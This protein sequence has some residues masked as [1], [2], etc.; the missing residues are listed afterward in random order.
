MVDIDQSNLQAILN[1]MVKI[2]INFIILK[3]GGSFCIPD[4]KQ[5]NDC[6]RPNNSIIL[7]YLLFT[8]KQE[9]FYNFFQQRKGKDHNLKKMKMPRKKQNSIVSKKIFHC[10]YTTK[11]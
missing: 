4:I 7:I 1:K 2:V 6:G 5:G 3:N 10:Y 9:N 8:I 11:V